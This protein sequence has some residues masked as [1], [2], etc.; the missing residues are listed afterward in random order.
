MWSNL[1]LIL[2]TESSI[3]APGSLTTHNSLT[4]NTIRPSLRQSY[5]SKQLKEICNYLKSKNLANL[6]TKIKQ[7]PEK[8][9]QEKNSTK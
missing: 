4:Q 9:E 1:I 6:W 7:E 3:S 8:T 5:T 2:P